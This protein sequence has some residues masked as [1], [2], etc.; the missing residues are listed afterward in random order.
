MGK[1]R[2]HSYIDITPFTA[3]CKITTWVGTASVGAQHWYAKVIFEPNKVDEDLSIKLDRRAAIEHNKGLQRF[4]RPSRE[5][6]K[7]GEWTTNF[8]DEDAVRVAAIA[9]FRAGKM[10]DHWDEKDFSLNG[11]IFMIE[12]DPGT[13]QPQEILCCAAGFESEMEQLNGLFTDGAGWWW[14]KNSEERLDDLSSRWFDIM[15][16]VERRVSK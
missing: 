4:G 14:E 9:C 5:Y 1:L 2:R 16:S 11:A 12:G 7:P 10:R 6:V 13:A 15:A 8:R 3:Y